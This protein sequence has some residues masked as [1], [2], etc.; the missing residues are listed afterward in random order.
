MTPVRLEPV[1]LRSRV[2]HATTEPLRSHNNI[3]FSCTSCRL[4]SRVIKLTKH[5]IWKKKSKRTAIAAYRAN[6]RTA[7]I[8]VKA[9]EKDQIL[10]LLNFFSCSTQLSRKCIMLINVKMPT[11][12]GILTFISMIHTTFKS[13]ES[14]I[15]IIFQH[16]S[17][18]EQLKF[19]AQLS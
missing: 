11:I 13:F 4:A 10:S 12:V 7:G 1:A 2:K 16:F 8:V 18:Y 5:V 17:F 14:I 15:F 9:P 3:K 6:C 19:H